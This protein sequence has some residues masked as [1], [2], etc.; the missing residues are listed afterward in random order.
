M[1]GQFLARR[2][3]VVDVEGDR[4]PLLLLVVRDVFVKQLRRRTSAGPKGR[5]DPPRRPRRYRR[6]STWPT[7]CVSAQRAAWYMRA[8]RYASRQTSTGWSG[9]GSPPNPLPTSTWNGLPE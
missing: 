6:Q 3:E 2:G 9:S 5:P 7:G 1:E 4:V 8:P